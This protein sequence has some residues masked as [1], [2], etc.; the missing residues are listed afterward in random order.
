[1]LFSR[2][3]RRERRFRL[4]GRR[5]RGLGLRRLSRLG[6]GRGFRSRRGFG[7]GG[8][9]GFRRRRWLD[10]LRRLCGLGLR[11][12]SRFGLRRLSRLGQLLGRKLLRLADI[13]APLLQLLLDAVEHGVGHHPAIE[14]DRA[15]RVVVAR[16][17][18]VDRRRIGIAVDDGD[19]G[20]AQLGRLGNG[21]LLLVRVDDEQH[22]GE[23][24]HVLDAAECAFELV[25][26]AS[27]AQ[28][29][30]L[31]QPGVLPRELFLEL[32]QPLD[33]HRDRLPVGEHAAEPAVVDV[34]LAAAL[35]LGR[36]QVARLP[37]GADEQH[38][39]AAGD[40]I[41]NRFERVLQKRR[42]LLQVDDVRAVA[43]PEEI[44]RHLRVPATGLVTEMHAGFEKLTHR[45]RRQGHDVDP[46]PVAPPRESARP[47]GRTPERW[48]GRR[49]PHHVPACEFECAVLAIPPPRC[50]QKDA[51][52]YTSWTAS[53][54]AIRLIAALTAGDT[55]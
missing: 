10:G 42:R 26:L 9:F 4:H 22:V 39:A 46:F 43:D 31:G 55:A 36:H 27:H 12:L 19:Y 18:V 37:L 54:P 7:R 2:I 51:A 3:F 5:G 30:L 14:V 20:N 25:A 16:N 34:K 24:A 44:G 6:L 29:L 28:K 15:D 33:R 8:R 45:K 32:A 17:R 38:P 49:A 53:T 47:I 41:A 50:K 13:G 11:R 52:N 1:M 48:D 21:D 35:C 40:D 23:P